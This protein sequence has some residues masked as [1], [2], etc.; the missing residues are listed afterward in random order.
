MKNLLFSYGSNNPNQLGERIGRELDEDSLF[1][2]IMPETKRHFVGYSE[3]WQGGVATVIAAKDRATYGYCTYL[4]D[5][6]LDILD[7]YE[8]VQRG[9]YKRKKGKVILLVDGEEEEANCIYY[10]ASAKEYSKPSDKYLK[11][12]LET[13]NSFFRDSNGK[14]FTLQFMKSLLP[15]R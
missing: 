10:V 14:K 3:R 5:D 2:A 11:A 13:I 15:K 9:S 1:P 8:G 6:E 12:C 4:S 7:V